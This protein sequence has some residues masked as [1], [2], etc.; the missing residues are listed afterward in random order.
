MELS[1]NMKDYITHLQNP[2]KDFKGI[3]KFELK[4]DYNIIPKNVIIS[5]YSDTAGC[6]HIRNIFPMNYLNC[7]YGQSSDINLILSQ[8]LIFQEDI[9]QKTKAI[10][11]QRLMGQ[12]QLA[13]VNFYKENQ[14]RFGYKLVYDIDDFVW[15]GKLQGEDIPDYN[16]GKRTISKES[17]DACIEIM[18]KM[19]VITVST[20][21]LGDYIAGLGIDKKKI[22][23]LHNA[24]PQFFW[25][26]SQ[27]APIKSKLEKPTVIWTASPTHWLNKPIPNPNNPN[28]A[29]EEEEY[30]KWLAISYETKCGDMFQVWREWVIKN[31]KDKKINYVQMGGLPF[32]FNEIKDDIKVIEWVNSYKYHLTV[33]E[34]KADFGLA[35]LVPNYFNYSKSFIKYQEYCASGIVGLGTY[36]TNGNPSPYDVCKVKFPDNVTMAEIDDKF[37][38]LKYP[39][40]YN[41]I[42]KAQYAQLIDNNWYM[43]S[44]GYIDLLMDTL[45]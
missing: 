44:K 20:K 3:T 6:G 25:G 29:V 32:F 12:H 36:F 35:P 8:H 2:N 11:L 14:K 30:N 27:K 41:Q 33:K 17:Q 42:L 38:K 18:K 40:Y 31:V 10:I 7:V 24:I 37:E 45:N 1:Q 5:H 21:F 13:A 19:D 4:P 39:E 23:I 43:E 26:K 16:F 15:A 9:L 22:V 28:K 34:Q